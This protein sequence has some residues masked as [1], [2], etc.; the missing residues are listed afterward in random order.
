M[1]CSKCGSQDTQYKTGISKKNG[2]AWAGYKCNTC[3]GMTFVNSPAGPVA[4][5][6][7]AKVEPK[8]DW[9]SK[10][11]R[12]V[13]QN[14]LSHAV[15]VC[16]HTNPSLADAG[17]MAKLVCEMAEVFESWVYRKSEDQQAV[18][19]VQQVFNEES[20]F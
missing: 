3:N 11:R 15:N 1:N 17:E 5:Q 7:Q 20:P 19:D 13:R 18:A 8:V 10:D 16:T 6:P 12:I 4:A 14:S 9:D 2:K